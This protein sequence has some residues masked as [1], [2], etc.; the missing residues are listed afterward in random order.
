MEQSS[1]PEINPEAL[2]NARAVIT[3]FGFEA[4]ADTV[5]EYGGKSLTLVEGLAQH[6]D[7]IP[8]DTEQ[9]FL[10]VQG[11]VA[12]AEAQSSNR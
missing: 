10:K 4:H 5:I 2:E 12:I 11:Y 1:T 3:A 7:H 8:T 6:W 9:L